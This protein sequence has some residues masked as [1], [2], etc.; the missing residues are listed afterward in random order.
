[1]KRRY[2]F[3][4]TPDLIAVST[5]EEWA[6]R[7]IARLP[8]SGH[9]LDPRPL[10]SATAMFTSA[11]EVFESELIAAYGHFM[12]L[13]PAAVARAFAGAEYEWACTLA[14]DMRRAARAEVLSTVLPD[15]ENQLQRALR[16]IELSDFAHTARSFASDWGSDLAATVL[17]KREDIL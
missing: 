14:S 2:S 6:A 4:K 15:R 8:Q 16:S 17:R 7:Q 13:A 12:P 3:S 11:V 1:M 10:A 5:V 9:G